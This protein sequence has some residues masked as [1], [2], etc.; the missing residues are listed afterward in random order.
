MADSWAAAAATV[1]AVDTGPEPYGVA[2]PG[3]GGAEVVGDPTGSAANEGIKDSLLTASKSDR[4][5][6]GPVVSPEEQVLSFISDS[7]STTATAGVE[8][9]LDVLVLLMW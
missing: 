2:V 8:D 6:V 3:V 9:A 1:A 7:T 5:V 4:G